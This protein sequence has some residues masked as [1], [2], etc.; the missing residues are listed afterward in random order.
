MLTAYV[1][2]FNGKLQQA[3]YQLEMLEEKIE[4][5]ANL[6][7]YRL[8]ISYE[9]TDINGIIELNSKTGKNLYE[10]H[11]EV[12][13]DRYSKGKI[14][15]EALYY[16]FYVYAAEEEPAK[17]L[18][19]KHMELIKAHNIHISAQIIDTSFMK[20]STRLDCYAI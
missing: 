15:Q 20:P 4:R 12:T 5:Y 3:D 18:G 2:D 14:V 19:K 10:I 16:D 7:Y 1:E 6:G 9:N 13:Q 17:A 11:A 8:L